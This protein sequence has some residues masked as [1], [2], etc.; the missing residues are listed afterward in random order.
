MPIASTSP[1]A[2]E[3]IM[4]AVLDKANNQGRPQVIVAANQSEEHRSVLP[5]EAESAALDHVGGG[6]L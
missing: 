2:L 6:A 5:A 4:P 1:A 3:A